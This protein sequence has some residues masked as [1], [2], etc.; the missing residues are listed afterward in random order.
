MTFI[1][2]MEFTTPFLVP[3]TNGCSTAK[4]ELAN[5]LTESMLV[6]YDKIRKVKF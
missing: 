2:Y 4:C 6:S 5:F 3:K 1:F